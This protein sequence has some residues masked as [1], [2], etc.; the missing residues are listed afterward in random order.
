[1][2]EIITIADLWSEGINFLLFFSSI[3]YLVFSSYLILRFVIL[4]YWYE[5]FHDH[6]MDYSDLPSGIIFNI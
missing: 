5:Q 2:K 1:M 3:Y 4:I 6:F